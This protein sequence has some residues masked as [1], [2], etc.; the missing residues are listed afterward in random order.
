MKVG[1]LQINRHF[2]GIAPADIQAPVRPDRQKSLPQTDRSGSFS[3]ILNTEID[4]SQQLRFSAHAVKRI[5]ERQIAMTPAQMARLEEGVKR[6]D[7][8]GAR[9]S[10]ILMDNN[11]YIVSVKNKIVVTAIPQQGTQ[12]NV[13]TNIDSVSIV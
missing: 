13:F 3:E 2:Q 9:K 10:L 8:K 4:R 11:A 5:E 6:A 1:E 7:Q 12:G